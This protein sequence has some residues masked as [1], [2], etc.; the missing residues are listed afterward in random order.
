MVRELD[1]EQNPPYPPI[2]RLF[3]FFVARLILQ[4][5]ARLLRDPIC[6]RVLPLTA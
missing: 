3:M 1:E 4:P 5:G 6:I 2:L